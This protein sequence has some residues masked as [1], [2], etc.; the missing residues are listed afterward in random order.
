MLREKRNVLMALPKRAQ[1]QAGKR[2]ADSRGPRETGRRQPLPQ[3]AI[4]RGDDP[5]I[6][7]LRL[8]VAHALILLLLE[9]TQEFALKIQGNFA[10]L[11]QEQRAAI[12]R[13]KASDAILERAGEAPFTWPKN[14]LSYSSFGIEAQLTRMS[15]LSFRLLCL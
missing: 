1:P 2:S 4:G 9:S 12:G 15:G 10:N 6:D 14:S 3:I 5:H 8:I 11:I 13:F 7:A